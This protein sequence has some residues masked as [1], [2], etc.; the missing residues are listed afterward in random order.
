MAS[1]GNRV[2]LMLSCSTDGGVRRNDEPRASAS[3]TRSGARGGPG[4]E[5][6]EQL[7]THLER[8]GF[9]RAPR[10]LGVDEVGRQVLS[11]VE[12]TAVQYPTWLPAGWWR[13]RASR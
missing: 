10:F 4:E 6:T 12:G 5:L 2:T 9:D 13:A 8:V 3:A 11:F 7:L 1:D